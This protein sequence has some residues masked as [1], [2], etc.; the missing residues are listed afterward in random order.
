MGIVAGL[1]RR[2]APLEAKAAQFGEYAARF[3]EHIA[4][5]SSADHEGAT[6]FDAIIPEGVIPPDPI[7]DD[8]PPI[9]I[10]KNTCW[11]GTANGDTSAC[12]EDTTE[13]LYV[14]DGTWK[15]RQVDNGLV[16]E[17]APDYGHGGVPPCPR[18]RHQDQIPFAEVPPGDNRVL[19]PEPDGSMGGA[20]RVSAFP[21]KPPGD[22]SVPDFGYVA[23]T[24]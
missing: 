9:P 2:Q 21:P 6:R 5:Y 20:D 1:A 18:R 17:L 11:I 8:P 13:Y 3:N 10:P 15:I 24:G 4:T 14:E 12:G 19:W 22:L 23:G 16:S 7:E